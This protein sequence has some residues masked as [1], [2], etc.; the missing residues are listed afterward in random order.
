MFVCQPQ[1]TGSA[2]TGLETFG[3]MYTRQMATGERPRET[4]ARQTEPVTCKS[5]QNG[6]LIREHI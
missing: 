3:C 5:P 2:G 1:R 6:D 4:T